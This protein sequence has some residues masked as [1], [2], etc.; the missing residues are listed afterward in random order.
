MSL[1]DYNTTPSNVYQLEKNE[2]TNLGLDIIGII[3]V[4]KRKYGLYSDWIS[5]FF[6]LRM[7]NQCF[8]YWNSYPSK[9]KHKIFINK[10]FYL[11]N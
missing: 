6:H 10:N 4:K 8:M 2:I 5:N 1:L 9:N 11:I 7:G 3:Y